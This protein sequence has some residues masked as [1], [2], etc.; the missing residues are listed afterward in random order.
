[1]EKQDSGLEV[2][3]FGIPGYNAENVADR[4]E[5]TLPSYSTDLVVYLVNKNDVDLPNDISDRVLASDLLLRLRF[6]YQVVLT[7]PWRQKMRQSPERYEFLATQLD[8]IARYT[9]QRG[10]PVMFVFMKNYTWEGAEA[11]AEPGGFVATMRD[12]HGA[13]DTDSRAARVV[14]AEDV[15]SPFPRLDDHM[16]REAHEVLAHRLCEAISGGIGHAC[17]P[18]HWSA[19]QRE[20]APPVAGAVSGAVLVQQAGPAHPGTE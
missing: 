20:A 13:S 10:V 1:M 7:K 15:L 11:E 4:I 17:L 19:Q 14:L 2:L 6:L 18:A 3:N 5:A 12:A 16:R 8:R 9:A